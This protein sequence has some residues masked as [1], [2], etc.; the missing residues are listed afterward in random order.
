MLLILLQKHSTVLFSD[1][2]RSFTEDYKWHSLT[3][4]LGKGHLNSLLITCF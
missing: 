2:S 1:P 3:A 4:R